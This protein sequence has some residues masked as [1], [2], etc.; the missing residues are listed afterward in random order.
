MESMVSAALAIDLLKATGMTVEQASRQVA[1]SLSRLGFPIKNKIYDN[2]DKPEWE[3]VRGWREEL[4]KANKNPKKFGADWKWMGWVYASLKT[5]FLPAPK[6]GKPIA[7]RR[8]PQQLR[9]LHLQNPRHLLDDPK[10]R[11]VLALLDLAEIA[12]ADLRLIG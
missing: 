10:A 2:K 6:K 12:P 11:V 8:P 4:S 9:G 7:L 3:V 5:Q 1:T